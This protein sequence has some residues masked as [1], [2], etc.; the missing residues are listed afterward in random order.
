MN[1]GWIKIHRQLLEWEWYDDTNVVRLFLHC[2]LKANHKDK[3]YR[4]TTV[5]RGS[6]LTGRELLAKQTGLTI[7]E[8]RTALN[9]LKSTSELTIK[10]STKGTVIEVV[11]YHEYQ[12]ANQQAN[13]TV[14]NDQPASNQ[15]VT[16]NKN[17][18]NDK[19]EKND[20]N[21]KNKEFNFPFQTKQFSEAWSDWVIY[22]KEIKKPLT[23][24]AIKRQ[25]NT[26]KEM[27]EANA[28]E[29]ITNSISNGWAGLFEVK[30]TKGK[31]KTPKQLEEWKR[32]L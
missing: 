23:D 28:I 5:R 8:T 3:K 12:T 29:S 20:K 19:K 18:K 11:N 9:K 4:G 15:L 6:F 1:N 22:R 16:T 17:D 2:L 21:D 7:Q 10:S 14:T 30:A 27:T 32:A 26:L 24:T 25:L 13:Q 31:I